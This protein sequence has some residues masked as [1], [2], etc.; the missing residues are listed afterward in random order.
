MSFLSIYVVIFFDSSNSYF[1]D[2][3]LWLSIWLNHCQNTNRLNTINGLSVVVVSWTIFLTEFDHNKS[4]KADGH[5]T[6][7]ARKKKNLDLSYSLQEIESN[8]PP[9]ESWV[10]NIVFPHKSLTMVL[11]A[12]TQYEY[13]S[14]PTTL[15]G[16]IRRKIQFSCFFGA[17][18]LTA[19]LM[20]ASFAVLC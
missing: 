18:L 3:P 19:I 9:R 2:R 12:A 5:F 20:L 7:P 14:I 11:Q 16:H 4:S 17:F 1:E 13:L 15:L 10:W 8:L 6:L